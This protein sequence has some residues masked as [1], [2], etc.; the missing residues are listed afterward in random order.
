[1]FVRENAKNKQRGEKLRIMIILD[2]FQSPIKVTTC[3]HSFCASCI[4]AACPEP[5]GWNCPLCNFT[6][7]HSA[8]SLARNYFAEKIVES[9]RR[10]PSTVQA[11]RQHKTHGEFGLCNIHNQEITLCKSNSTIT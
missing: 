7:D 4:L 3:G 2:Q 8:S 1:M 10:Q 9:L 5:R 11:Q 6:H